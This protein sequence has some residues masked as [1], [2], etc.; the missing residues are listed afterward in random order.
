MRKYHHPEI[1]RFEIDD[2]LYQVCLYEHGEARFWVTGD[3]VRLGILTEEDLKWD[4]TWDL[5]T[6]D[7][8]DQVTNIHAHS[9]RVLRSVAQRY[10]QYVCKHKPFFVYYCIPKDLRLERVVLKLLE[11]Y[12]EVEDLYYVSSDY[13]KGRVMFHLKQSDPER[14]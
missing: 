10:A 3:P 5:P 11:R 7:S 9:L 13:D 1:A 14:S 12:S 6:I 2:L 8:T 4:C